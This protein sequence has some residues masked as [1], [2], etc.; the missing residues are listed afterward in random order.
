MDLI[1]SCSKHI[2]TLGNN[3]STKRNTRAKDQYYYSSKIYTSYKYNLNT[4][5][6]P[7]DRAPS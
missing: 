7:M 1:Q 6:T 2:V 5:S 3:L 4:T